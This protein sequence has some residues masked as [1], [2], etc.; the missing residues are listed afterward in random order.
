MLTC[1]GCIQKTDAYFGTF[2]TKESAI[3]IDGDK[4]SPTEYHNRRE[5]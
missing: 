3:S 1:F 2:G 5:Y 4:I